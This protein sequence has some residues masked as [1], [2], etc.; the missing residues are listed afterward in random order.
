MSTYIEMECSDFDY[1]SFLTEHFTDFVI[2]V[3]GSWKYEDEMGSYK[4][5]TIYG[6]RSTAIRERR[7]AQIK[8][9]NMAMLEAVL[10]ACE[11][12][13]IDGKQIFVLSPTPLG[14]R[15][16]E[17]RKGVNEMFIQKIFQVCSEKNLVLNALSLHNG[18]EFVRDLL[19]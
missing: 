2:I 5:R 15:S 18:G 17:K 13:Q 9:P 7:F 16:A 19:T 8:S 6:N 3:S 4:H 11:R 14:F 10:D 1:Q 12:I